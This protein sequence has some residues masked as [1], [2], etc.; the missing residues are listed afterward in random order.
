MTQNI[1]KGMN[2]SP[3][4]FKRKVWGSGLM[5]SREVLHDFHNVINGSLLLLSIVV[6]LQRKINY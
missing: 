1:L 5:Y 6:D 2:Q 3:E 4:K